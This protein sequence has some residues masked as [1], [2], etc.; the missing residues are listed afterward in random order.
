MYAEAEQKLVRSQ[1][2]MIQR[3]D[4]IIKD[5]MP[6]CLNRFIRNILYPRLQRRAYQE[7]QYTITLEKHTSSKRKREIYESCL[8]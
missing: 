7:K 2:K 3:T 8:T 1:I 6:T 5:R 4:I